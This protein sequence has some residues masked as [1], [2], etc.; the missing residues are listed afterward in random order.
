MKVDQQEFANMTIDEIKEK[1]PNISKEDFEFHFPTKKIL[2]FENENIN[3][4]RYESLIQKKK[5]FDNYNFQNPIKEEKSLSGLEIRQIAN[6]E[7]KS[8]P[9][10]NSFKTEIDYWEKI[11]K[12]ET[13]N[14]FSNEGL[15]PD[16]QNLYKLFL[17]AYKF[18]NDVD[19]LITDQS[20]KN[21]EPIIKYFSFDTSFSES[22][23]LVKKCGNKAL[24]P[25]F[26]KGLLLIG[27][28]GNGKTSIMKSMEF[29]IDFHF[30]KA[31][32][33]KWN[34]SGDWA[35]IRFRFKTTE[36]LVSEFEYLKTQE[37]KDI[38]FKNQSTGNILF[39]DLKR[40]KNASNYGITNVVASVLEKR[41][42]HFKSYTSEN[43][44][45]NFVS[46]GTMNFHDEYP[47]DINFAI[48]DCGIRYGSHVYDRIFELFNIVEI[49]GKSQRK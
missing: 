20:I 12:S 42:N 28:V 41:Y 9:D 16:K 24:A 27:N 43:K 36:S 32:E 13:K 17:K 18:L 1:F 33:E 11:Y 34:T 7:N 3:F 14:V 22:E 8:K 21:L 40:E 48:Q 47:N 31:I 29:L 2:D 5:D 49:K 39:D 10:P 6:F 30:K 23:N 45:K 26:K 4:T 37:E 44:T 19:F 35:K 15:I 38:F 25:S 46:H